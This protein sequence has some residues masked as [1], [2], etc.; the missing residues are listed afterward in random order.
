MERREVIN[1]CGCTEFPRAKRARTE[2][3][4]PG[5]T[6]I[7]EI[8][9]DALRQVVEFLGA[10]RWFASVCKAF[11]HVF[12][13]TKYFF[14]ELGAIATQE[15]YS[16]TINRRRSIIL[17]KNFVVQTIGL[18]EE[19]QNRF[20]AELKKLK[21]EKPLLSSFNDAVI[22]EH[23][24]N[25][26]FV[27]G[28]MTSLKIPGISKILNSMP[29]SVG[30]HLS[31]AER[32]FLELARRKAFTVLKLEIHEFMAPWFE[33]IQTKNIP[34][35]K[36]IKEEVKALR[37]ESDKFS[38]RISNAS[39]TIE[40]II[41]KN[42]KYSTIFK[43]LGDIIDENKKCPKLVKVMNKEGRRT[44][45]FSMLKKLFKVC[46]RGK[47]L[48]KD[49]DTIP[50]FAMNVSK[51]TKREL[52]DVNPEDIETCCG[53]RKTSD[54]VC[55]RMANYTMKIILEKFHGLALQVFVVLLGSNEYKI[56][57]NVLT[58]ENWKDTKETLCALLSV[59]SPEYLC[60]V[61]TAEAQTPNPPRRMYGSLVYTLP[62]A[63]YGMGYHM[64][65]EFISRFNPKVPPLLV[66]SKQHYLERKGFIHDGANSSQF[67]FRLT[68]NY[69]KLLETALGR[70]DSMYI[71]WTK[72]LQ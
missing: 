18:D 25:F 46:Y 45:E 61:F 5:K 7:L 27:V 72:R 49:T 43:N 59:Y 40:S 13:T 48:L 67:N 23:F 52:F 21:K 63:M 44:P 35:F 32:Y 58:D 26:S 20:C 24:E 15:F 19:T 47:L 64:F 56:V 12:R 65:V 31:F 41:M 54:V 14:V 69:V 2:L 50:D 71:E 33:S 66:Q 10:N 37:S 3:E 1:M 16:W 8:G 17:N 36:E 9:E 51:Y 34:S 28:V 57:H 39:H 4:K 42:A 70:E 62:E 55:S 38:S 68:Q 11:A 60:K 29:L 53:N 30:E 22:P 6:K